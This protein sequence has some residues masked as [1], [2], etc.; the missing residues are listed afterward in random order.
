MPCTAD[1]GGAAAG[2]VSSPAKGAMAGPTPG[3]AGMLTE[4]CADM[5]G[6]LNW[7]AGLREAYA[8]S[9]LAA[10]VTPACTLMP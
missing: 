8:A 5:P 9:W 10:D 1:G 6:P 2:K 4:G 3:A 7:R